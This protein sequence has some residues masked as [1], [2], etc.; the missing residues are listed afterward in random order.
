VVWL[1]GYRLAFVTVMMAA[2]ITSPA[3]LK[4]VTMGLLG[5]MSSLASVIGAPFGSAIGGAFGW[6]HGM[7]AYAGMAL[8]G[9]TVFAILYPRPAAAVRPQASSMGHTPERRR[10]VWG[11]PVVWGL[12]ALGLANVGGF[13]STFF[14]PSA[15]KT[16][17][18][19]DTM[20][21]AYVISAAYVTAIFLNLLVGYLAD[22]FNRWNVLTIVI[23]AMIPATLGMTSGNLRVFQ[24]ATISIISLGL[25]ATNQI[26]AVAGELLPGRELGPVMGIVSL[27]SGVFGYAGPQ[28]L[29]VLRDW[30]GGFEA[31]WFFLTIAAALAL[32]VVALSRRRQNRTPALAPT[33]A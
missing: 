7:L 22:R 28:A 30:T 11:N 21:A 13:S 14:V 27:G 31:G 26:Y 3:S 17:F 24:L 8:L 20:S 19:Q 18:H 2:A 15:L 23:A 33:A 6:R 9:A 12:A 29:G 16:V 32:I 5:A 4:S 1:V 25:A 10:S